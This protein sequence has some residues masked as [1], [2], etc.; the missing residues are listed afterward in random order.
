MPC[1]LQTV[2]DDGTKTN[3]T[4]NPLFSVLRYSPCPWMTAFDYHK[5][6]VTCMCLYGYHLS[7]VIYS[8]NGKVRELWPINPANVHTI[9]RNA[10]TGKLDFSLRVQFKQSATQVYS[11]KTIT[12]TGG[13]D[14]FYTYYATEDGVTPISPVGQNKASIGL[15]MT[16]TDHGM[17][18]FKND[19]TP[20]LVVMMPQA[21]TPEQAKRFVETWKATGG[22]NSYG[23]PRI[24]EQGATVERLTMSNEDAQYLETRQFQ[25]DEI[26]GIFGVPPHMV[27][28]RQQAKGW[29]TME[30]LMNEFV[31]LSINPW[32]FRMEGSITKHLIPRE[33]WGKTSAK[34]STQAL[35]RGD[36]TAR[37]A[38]YN[39]LFAMGAINPNEIRAFEDLNPR[40][41][42]NG[43][44][45][46][47]TANVKT[48]AQ[49]EQEGDTTGDM[50]DGE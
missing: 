8:G 3:D 2:A 24:L 41:D 17:N 45:F 40:T 33:R 25:T 18:V 15:A 13:Q 29:S 34:Y 11:E 21:L 14:A 37:T 20:P 22:N 46:Y 16:A 49:L 7:K 36:T 31:T 19:A 43:N 30:Q 23:L 42:E 39:A 27:G 6:N 35:L 32:T 1:R 12:L 10:R 5:F 47:V 44:Q 28:S 9:S 48:P 38:L 26:A 4:A 50:T